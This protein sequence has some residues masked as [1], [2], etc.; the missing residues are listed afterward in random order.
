MAVRAGELVTDGIVNAG[1]RKLRGTL[2]VVAVFIGAFTLALTTGIG[3]G[4][5]AY[6]DTQLESMGAENTLFVSAA[7]EHVDEGD[8]VEYRQGDPP[9][10]AAVDENDLAVVEGLAGVGTAALVPSVTPTFITAPGSAEFVFDLGDS[11]PGMAFSIVAGEQLDYD[12]AEP[13]IALP[14][15][16][17]DDLGFDSAGDA[18]GSTVTIGIQDGVGGMHRVEA[19]VAG[20]IARTLLEDLPRGNQQL[21]Q[22]LYDA[23]TTGMPSEQRGQFPGLVVQ[24]SDIEV[25]TDA[26]TDAGYAVSSLSDQLGEFQSVVDGIVLV[27]N[28]FAVLALLTAAFGIVNVLLMS[29][30]ERTREIGILRALGM[31][32]WQVFALIA[33]EAAWIAFLGAVLAVAAAVAAGYAISGPLAEALELRLEGLRLIAFTPEAIV[34]EIALIVV[35]ALVAAILPAARAARLDPIEAIRYE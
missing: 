24:A 22:D 25:A 5:R 11:I 30:Q 14:E 19:T 20:V 12:A 29:V 1:R 3:T 10:A 2:T 27:L 17:L 28:I 4:V 13:Q 26:L 34:G 35:I 31:P 6:I 32:R 8:L 18:V 33:V 23:Q 9:G 7:V 16:Y 21:V 15:S